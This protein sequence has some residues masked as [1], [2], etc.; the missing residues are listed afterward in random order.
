[1]SPVKLAQFAGI[2]M[3]G[4]ILISLSFS[5]L[6]MLPIAPQKFALLFSLGSMTVL[7]SVAFLKGPRSFAGVVLQKDKLIFTGLYGV[8]LLGTL[9]ATLIAR[10]YLFTAIFALSQTTGLA[11]FLASFVPGGRMV[12]NFF[13]RMTGRLAGMVIR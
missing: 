5:F 4:M 13:G 3:V 2:F 8:G 12:L 11:Y 7:G 9:W 6:P 1:M 10:S